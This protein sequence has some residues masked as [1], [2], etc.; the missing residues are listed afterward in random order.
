MFLLESSLT[1]ACTVIDNKILVTDS[2]AI[3][4]GEALVATAGR[5]TKCGAAGVPQFIALQSCA[6]GTDSKID[7]MVVRKDQT[8][9]A[10]VAGTAS[11]A[12]AAV[13]AKVASI[14]ST[15]L[16]L[17]AAALTGGNLEIVSV[18]TDKAKARV[19]FNL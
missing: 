11:L 2:E 1:G 13:G 7:Y 14:D 17:D 3:S 5:L 9:L 8:F 4:K 16:K 15:G 6:A 19:R 10:D 18:D 12:A